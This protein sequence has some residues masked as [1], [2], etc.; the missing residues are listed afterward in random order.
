MSR[1]TPGRIVARARRAL[2][3]PRGLTLTPQN[4]QAV[5]SDLF[6]WRRDEGW[7]TYFELLDVFSLIEPDGVFGQRSVDLAIFD[8]SGALLIRESIEVSPGRRQSVHVSD[9]V[10]ETGGDYGTFACFHSGLGPSFGETGVFLAERG[11]SGYARRDD[12]PRSYVHG[13]L[14]AVAEDDAG[15]TQLGAS[16][17]IRSTYRLQLVVEPG[18]LFELALVNPTS[19]RQHLSVIEDF[20]REQD[21]QSIRLDPRESA[22]VRL[23][24]RGAEPSRVAVRSRLPM[25]R[26]V[27]FY[28]SG[29]AF[30]VFHG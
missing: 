11:Y 17:L 30:D 9:L 16:G 24:T 26:P 25:A 10:P 6:L 15:S 28:R 21:V 2:H 13:N 3:A 8:R 27:V 5:I 18:A 4:R 22:V 20:G 14:D 1:L 23:G 7:E 29:E 12:G 19:R